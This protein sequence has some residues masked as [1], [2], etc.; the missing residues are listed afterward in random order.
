[1]RLPIVKRTYIQILKRQGLFE[2][3]GDSSLLLPICS[4]THHSP[5]LVNDKDDVVMIMNQPLLQSSRVEA[6]GNK[7]VRAIIKGWWIH[8]TQEV[9]HHL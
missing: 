4:F 2:H 6:K 8:S 1:M 3:R 9:H 5:V 7:G